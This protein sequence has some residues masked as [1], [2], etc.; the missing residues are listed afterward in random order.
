MDNQSKETSAV[1]ATTMSSPIDLTNTII[2]IIVV[3]LLSSFISGLL[4][5]YNKQ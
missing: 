1:A 5:F 3:L 2:S 4:Y